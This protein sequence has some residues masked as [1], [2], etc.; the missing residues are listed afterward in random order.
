MA[1]VISDGQV[2]IIHS[3]PDLK[4]SNYQA[5]STDISIYENLVR[6]IL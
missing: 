3:I 6:A 1:E 5:I 4:I 2:V